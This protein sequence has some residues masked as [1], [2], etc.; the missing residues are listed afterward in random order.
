MICYKSASIKVTPSPSGGMSEHRGKTLQV[1]P[2]LLHQ[3]VLH[4]DSLRKAKILNNQFMS[5]FT[6]EDSS[7][8]TYLYGPDY[9]HIEDL[10]ISREGVEKRLSNLNITKSAGPDSIPLRKAKIA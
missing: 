5:V 10:T 6:V 9:P 3:G 4:T 7:N 2:P 8:T 1:S